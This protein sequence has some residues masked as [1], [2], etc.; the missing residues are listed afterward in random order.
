MANNDIHLKNGMKNDGYSELVGGE[1][2]LLGLSL[3]KAPEY[4]TISLIC[5]INRLN[6]RVQ[7]CVRQG[8]VCVCV[9]V[10]TFVFLCV[11]VCVCV[12]EVILLGK[13]TISLA[14][15]WQENLAPD[16]RPS[17]A[18]IYDKSGWVTK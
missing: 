6:R 12:Y 10:C 15:F 14:H 13:Q 1:R 18:S 5:M 7:V 16:H 3:K 2:L 17:N 8:C 11:C 4:Y 9:C